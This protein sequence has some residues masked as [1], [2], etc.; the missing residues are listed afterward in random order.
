MAL[1]PVHSIL[2]FSVT[3]KNA[4]LF[5]VAKSSPGLKDLGSSLHNVPLRSKKLSFELFVSQ[6]SQG[7]LTV[8]CSICMRLLNLRMFSPNTQVKKKNKPKEVSH[9]LLYS[10]M[11]LWVHCQT[12]QYE[13]HRLTRSPGSGLWYWPSLIFYSSFPYSLLLPSPTILTASPPPFTKHFAQAFL[14]FFFLL[15]LEIFTTHL[16]APHL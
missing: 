12:L 6:N 7:N 3:S 5:L 1:Q 15:T 14:T 2:Y 11:Y 10:L 4:F 8:N 16:P 13:K 9:A